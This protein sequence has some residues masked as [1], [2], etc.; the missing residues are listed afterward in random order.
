[1]RRRG[2]HDD[3]ADIDG[4]SLV[5]VG[6][7][8][9]AEADVGAGV[10]DGEGRAAVSGSW[11]TASPPSAVTPVTVQRSD[12]ARARPGRLAAGGRSVW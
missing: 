12:C 4:V 2:G 8:G 1:M 3:D 5:A 11:D 9:V 7:S 6:G 10:V